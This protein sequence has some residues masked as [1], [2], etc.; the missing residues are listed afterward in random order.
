[1]IWAIF[2]KQ[3]FRV[4]TSLPPPSL[5]IH[6][7]V[8]AAIRAGAEA[9]AGATTAA[10]PGFPTS[11]P[12]LER[13]VMVLSRNPLGEHSL[14]RFLPLDSRDHILFKEGVRTPRIQH[15]LTELYL[16]IPLFGGSMAPMGSPSG[17]IQRNGTFDAGSQS[18]TPVGLSS[19]VVFE[20]VFK[21]CAGACP[22]VYAGPMA[23]PGGQA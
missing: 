3:I 16:H 4:Q 1:M 15:M 9:G 17:P 20:D 7:G 8:R 11:A 13:V 22:H 14:F 19:C 23:A 2:G 6:S 5:L 21:V 18:V 12:Q 10:P